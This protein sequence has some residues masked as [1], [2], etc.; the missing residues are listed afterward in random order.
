MAELGRRGGKKG[1]KRRLETLTKE[2]RSEIALKAARARWKKAAAVGEIVHRIPFSG[3][4]AK[5]IGAF[6][7]VL[8][9]FVESIREDREPL[10]G[11]R[12]T[13]RKHLEL[14]AA[15]YQSA[16]ERKAVALPLSPDSPVY[17][18]GVLGLAELNSPFG[19]NPLREKNLYGVKAEA[20]TTP[21]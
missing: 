18:K 2:R 20:R 12:T 11:F 19:L 9:D 17:Q 8:K 1:G 3:T 5:L 14:I 6:R 21:T 13:G 16:V 4:K 10:T 15:G 7:D